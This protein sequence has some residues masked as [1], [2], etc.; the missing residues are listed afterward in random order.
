MTI[1]EFNRRKSV[2]ERKMKML[3]Q[4]LLGIVMIFLG[5]FVA[6]IASQGVGPVDNDCGGALMVMLLGAVLAF[7]RDYILC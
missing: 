4:K 7:S 3:I 6:Y 1:R 2:R 5:I